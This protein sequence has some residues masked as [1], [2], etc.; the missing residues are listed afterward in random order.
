MVSRRHSRQTAW[1]YLATFPPSALLAGRFFRQTL[2]RLGARQPLCGT[3]VTSL[4]DLTSRPPACKARMDDSRP[5]PGP[6]TRTSTWRTP[7]SLAEVAA[8]CAAICA[9]KGVPLREP[10]KL[11]QPVDDHASTFPFG[12][13]MVMI[14]LLNVA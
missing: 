9:A 10:L 2:R 8:A 13:V 4:M 3:G 7:C 1:V 14:V 12:S 11:L 6:F 5:E